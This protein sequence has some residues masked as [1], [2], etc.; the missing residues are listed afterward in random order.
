MYCFLVK[1]VLG[2][3][4]LDSSSDLKRDLELDVHKIPLQDL[5]QRFGSDVHSGLNDNQVEDS[6]KEH[7]LN[8][9]TPPPKTPEWVRFCKNLFSG[10]SMLLWIG[11]FLCFIAYFIQ[12]LNNEDPPKDN[13]YLGIVLALVVTVTGIFSYYQEAK[14]ARIM[15]SFKDLVPHH[16]LVRRNGEVIEV[17]VKQLTLGLSC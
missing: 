14:S 12:S 3:K 11:A 6:Q 9:L 13:L 2:S 7:G 16:A 17:N 1:K 15:E 4:E 8:E 10:F 5:L